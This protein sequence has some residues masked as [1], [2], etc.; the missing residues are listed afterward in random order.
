MERDRWRLV[1]VME[2]LG[3]DIVVVAHDELRKP[4]PGVERTRSG[5][6]S[7]DGPA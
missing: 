1:D 3:A 5:V 7:L 2:L 6:P 4:T